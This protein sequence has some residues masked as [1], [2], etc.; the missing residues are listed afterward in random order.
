M[1]FEGGEVVPE[2]QYFGEA[3]EPG[4]SGAQW[5]ERME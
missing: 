2:T 4:P 1:E 5:V 3:F